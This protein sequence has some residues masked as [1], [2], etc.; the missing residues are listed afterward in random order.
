MSKK[1]LITG[2]S[3][4]LANHLMDYLEQEGGGILSGLT[5]VIDFQSSRLKVFHVDLRDKEKVFNT[6]LQV[7]PDLVFHLAAI[8]NVGFSWKHQKLTYEVNFIGSSNLLEALY[9][10]TPKCRVIMMSSAEL[11][12]N[13]KQTPYRETDKPCNP[14][15]PYALSKMAMEMCVDLYSDSRGMDILKIRAFNFTGPYQDSKFV[16]SDFSHQIAQIE[17]GLLEPIMQV[18]NLSAVRDLSDVRD[19]ARYLTVIAEKGESGSKNKGIYNTCSGQ[20]YSIRQLLEIL[21]SLS[22]KEI[23]VKVDQTKLRPV[24]VPILWGDNTLIRESFGLTPKYELRQTLTDLLN[25]WRERV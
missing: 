21:L 9:E 6:V 20:T 19:V 24:D 1:I 16:A 12:G 23:E 25:Y 22:S 13:T 3:G 7:Q 2:C 5:E 18:G 10:Y 15:N 4:F 8:A 17:K 11:Y 14:K